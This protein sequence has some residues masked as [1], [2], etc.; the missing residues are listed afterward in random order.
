MIYLLLVPIL[1]VAWFAQN[2][3]HELSHLFVGKVVEGRKSIKLIPYW[4]KF[5]GSLYFS[6]YECGPATKSGSPHYR[7]IAPLITACFLISLWVVIILFTMSIFFLP[8]ILCPLVDAVVWLYG[9]VYNKE[10]T[11]G[12][13]YKIIKK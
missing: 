4:H 11:D 3:I 10:F 6:R 13:Y 8:L 5:E 9:Y 2:V 1:L 12:Y 7:L